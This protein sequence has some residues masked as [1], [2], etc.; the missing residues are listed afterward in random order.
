MVPPSHK[1]IWQAE[2]WSRVTTFLFWKATCLILFGVAFFAAYFQTLN[3]PVFP[4]TIIPATALDRL[5]GFHPG[6][7]LLYI[8][9]WIYIPN[10]PLLMREKADLA[11]YARAAGGLALVGL[12]LFLFWPTAIGHAD[13]DGSQYP[14]VIFLKKVDTSGNACPSLHVAFAVFTACWSSRLLRQMGDRG[15]WRLVNWAWCVGIAY[16]TLATK[17]HV[18]IDVLAGAALGAAVAGFAL[19]RPGAT[20]GGAR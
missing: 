5:I 10:V 14:S 6:A 17:Q 18:A 15:T 16:S 4:V 13:I 11:A 7:L 20:V 3:H 12:A 1:P 2:L 19:A 8:S 9:L